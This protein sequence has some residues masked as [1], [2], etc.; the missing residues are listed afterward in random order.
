MV[1]ATEQR[2]EADVLDDLAWYCH[3]AKRMTV[4]DPDYAVAHA[5]LNERLR[6]LGY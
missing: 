6:E 4:V 5:V 1:T 2:T 3:R